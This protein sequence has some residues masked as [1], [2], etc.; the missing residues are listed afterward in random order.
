MFFINVS[1]Q[2]RPIFERPLHMEQ[3]SS[4]VSATCRFSSVALLGVAPLGATAFMF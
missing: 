4:E 3:V 2:A 1:P